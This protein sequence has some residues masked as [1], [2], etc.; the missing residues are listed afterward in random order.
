LLTALGL[1][2]AD[3]SR[4]F[5]TL[6]L[7]VGALGG[8]LGALAGSGLAVL[9][10]RTR[11]LPLPRGVFVVSHVPFRV[12]AAALVVV[13]AVSLGSAL[14]ASLAPARAAARRDILEGLRYE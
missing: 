14:L 1:R 13:L 5:V 7:G 12:T 9:L 10:D 8:V 2:P 11:A 4:L 3:V 6:G